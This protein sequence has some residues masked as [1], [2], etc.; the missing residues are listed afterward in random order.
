MFHVYQ[1]FAPALAEDDWKFRRLVR[2][3]VRL[4]APSAEYQ[5]L[6]RSCGEASLPETA[7]SSEMRLPIIAEVDAL[8]AQAFDLSEEEL[9][10]ILA[11]FYVTDGAQKEATLTEFARL[12]NADSAE[13]QSMCK[14]GESARVEFKS[15]ARW[16]LRL[17]QVSKGLEHVVV[18][19]IASF[20]NSDG[21]TLLI[22]V[23][24]NGEILGLAPDFK[25]FGKRPNADGFENWLTG[26]LL[27]A[28]G[29]DRTRLLRVSFQTIEGK[30]VCRVDVDRSLRPVYAPDE[31]GAETF[32]VRAGNST[33]ELS[34]SEAHAYV[35]EHFRAQAVQAA[36]VSDDSVIVSDVSPSRPEAQARLPIEAPTV[37]RRVDLSGHGLFRK[38]VAGKLV[39]VPPKAE[40]D[41]EE[42]DDESPR[43]RL[44]DQF[45]VD[46]V[47]AIIRDVVSGAAPMPRE[48]VI[49]D[50]ATHLGA[51]RVGAR[52][53]DFIDGMLNTASRRYIIETRD[54]GLV[55]SARSIDD[56]HRDFLKTALKAVIGR[57]WTEEDEAIRAATRYLGFRR[58]GPKIERAFRSAINGLLRQDELERDGSALRRRTQ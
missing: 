39:P 1:L 20:M 47:L 30:T 9:R 12:G 5:S 31:K 49:K 32:Y 10:Y 8:I 26:L 34:I 52:I 7:I 37:S 28:I 40:V 57:T 56:Y 15:S 42:S 53:R 45:E 48:D 44:I 36:T 17:L 14:T 11:T 41:G 43:R 51:E 29:R 55:A 2:N 38:Q 16:D 54:G 33:R 24:D 22:G 46:D 3:A 18:K 4:L 58:T 19:T 25:T 50:V 35:D 27:E 21:G 13:I 23:A 6:A